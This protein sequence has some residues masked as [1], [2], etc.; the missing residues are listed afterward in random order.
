MG[1]RSLDKEHLYESPGIIAGQHGPGSCSTSS[2]CNEKSAISTAVPFPSW[3]PLPK[4]S[5]TIKLQPADLA[6]Q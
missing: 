3:A 4:C 6:A 5:G 1:E 2:L